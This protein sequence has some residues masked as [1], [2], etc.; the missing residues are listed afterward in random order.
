MLENRKFG[1]IF[2][3]ILPK[4]QEDETTK[5]MQLSSIDNIIKNV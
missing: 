3:E 2:E 1:E 5:S 4:R